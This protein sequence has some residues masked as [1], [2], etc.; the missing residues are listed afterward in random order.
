MRLGLRCRPVKPPRRRS[1]LV[2]LAAIVV[3]AVVGLA[4]AGGPAP[5]VQVAKHKGGTYT[6]F[7]NANVPDGETKVRYVRVRSRADANQPANLTAELDVEGPQYT[8]KWFAGQ[9]NITPEIEG[10]GYEFVLKPNKDRIFKVK[11]KAPQEA[12]GG[13]ITAAVEVPTSTFETALIR[14]NEG[15]CVI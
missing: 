6:G 8:I 14:I 5:K 12:E 15:V 3:L 4:A 2:A 9:E 11:I 10:D 1:L 7:V 13:C